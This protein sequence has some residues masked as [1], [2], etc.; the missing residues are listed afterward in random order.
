MVWTLLHTGAAPLEGPVLRVPHR[1]GS[2]Y[3]DAWNG[4]ILTP[5]ITG[6]SSAV[7]SLSLNARDAGC[8]VQTW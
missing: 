6:D 5:E 8:V 1:V 7:L 3:L 2:R 4:R